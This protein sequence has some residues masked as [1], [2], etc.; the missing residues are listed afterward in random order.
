MPETKRS[1][2]APAALVIAFVA[3]ALAV[4][5]LVRPSS[6]SNTS[7]LS[8]DE[9]KTQVCAAFDMVRQAV[10]LQTN[11][12][13]GPERVAVQAVA[14]NARLATL[15]GGQFLLARLDG[16]P[17][18]ADLDEAVRSFANQ[19]EYIGMKQL[20]GGSAADPGQATHMSDAQADAERVV[21]LCR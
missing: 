13:L 1:W 3:V 21:E 18:S 12:N 17:V 2:I 4:W 14:A 9:A 19:L 11:A 20:A 6:S 15:G 5:G 16:S 10:S 7:G 8:P